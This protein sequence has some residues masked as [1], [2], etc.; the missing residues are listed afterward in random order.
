MLYI[1][2]GMEIMGERKYGD[3]IQKSPNF[4]PQIKMWYFSSPHFSKKSKV[5]IFDKF[6]EIK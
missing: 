1:I 5:M 6:N 4:V 3:F 2:P